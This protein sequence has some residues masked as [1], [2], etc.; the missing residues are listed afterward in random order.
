MRALVVEDDLEIANIIVKTLNDIE[1]NC[2]TEK[3]GLAAL[4]RVILE[5]FDI[6]I[7]DLMIPDLDG[8]SF[9][10]AIR[11]K[12]VNTPVL[13]S[14]ALSDLPDRLKG[15]T[16]GGDD[17]LTKP[18][19]TSEL[20]I[21]A[22]NLIKRSRNT[23][24]QLE[25]SIQDLQLNRL[26]REVIRAGKK[27]DLQD[28]EFVLLTLFM[29]NKDKVLSKQTILKEV[30]NYDFDPQTNVVDVLV[31]RLREKVEKGHPSRLIF[32]VRGVGYTMRESI[33]EEIKP[34][35]KP[36][37]SFRLQNTHLS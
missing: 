23:M 1:I 26:K 20:Q 15:L 28:R 22:K 2:V 33:R 27:I 6:I 24:E 31:C 4:E 9:L 36:A 5:K 3:S 21:R 13:I 7:L 25:I 37:P 35:N 12:K 10:K 11:E 30:W 32:T 14:S 19:A 29:N 17:Y 34:M 16:L 8:Y 18:F